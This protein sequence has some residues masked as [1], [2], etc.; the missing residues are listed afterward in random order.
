MTTDAKVI[1][2]V[3][4]LEG[5]SLRRLLALAWATYRLTDPAPVLRHRVRD[6]YMVGA[7]T[8]EQIISE[9]ED[10]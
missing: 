10:A 7:I 1:A 5:P 4:D 2:M 6:Q 8:G 3:C 9:W